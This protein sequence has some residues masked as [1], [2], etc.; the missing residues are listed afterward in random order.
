[1]QAA[2]NGEFAA[3]ATHFTAVLELSPCDA[4]LHEQHA[5]CLMELEQYDAAMTAAERAT[6]IEPQV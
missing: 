6:I 3:A 2:E 4:A 5:Q 1:M